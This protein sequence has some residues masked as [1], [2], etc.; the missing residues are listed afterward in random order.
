MP[1]D[2]AENDVRFVEIAK[3]DDPQAIRTAEFHPN[4]KYFAIG[5]NSKLLRVFQYS[6]QD[7]NNNTADR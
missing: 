1:G 4:G 5:S 3:F 7:S 6:S 2:I